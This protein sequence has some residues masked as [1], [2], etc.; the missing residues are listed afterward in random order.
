MNVAL[1]GKAEWI[2]AFADIDNGRLTVID[3]GEGITPETLN[4]ILNSPSI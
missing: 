1:E 3:D 2:E 4:E